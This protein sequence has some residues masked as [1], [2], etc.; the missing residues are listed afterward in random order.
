VNRA[1]EATRASHW[2][3][4]AIAIGASCL[5][6]AT[7]INKTWYPW[8]EGTLGQMAERTLAG[9]LPHRE[10][11]DTYTGGLTFYNAAIFWLFGTDLIWL[12][13]AMVPFFVGFVVAMYYIGTHLLAPAG[14]A[15]LTLAA[16]VW[17]LPTYPAAI[18][19]WYGLFL[20][21]IGI[22]AILR[23]LETGRSRWLVG[24]GLAG[25]VS[26]V[27]K[28]V[29]AYYVLGVLLFFAFRAVS[30]C[31]GGWRRPRAAAFAPG[32]I[33]LLVAGFTLSIVDPRLTSAELIAF[34]VPNVTVCLAVV[35]LAF[36]SGATMGDLAEIARR[37]VLPFVGG[38]LA[39]VMVFCVPYV[40]TG[41]LG[42]LIHDVIV[43]PRNRYQYAAQPPLS[44]GHLHSAIPFVLLF[45]ITWLPRRPRDIAAGIVAVG[46]L[47]LA[48]VPT[49][50]RADVYFT[51]PARELVP[52]L[53]IAA[54]GVLVRSRSARGD[55]LALLAFVM[56]LMT[57]VQFPFAVTGYFFYVF[58]L[59]L[60]AAVALVTTAD[61]QPRPMFA[62]VLVAYL[63]TG[64]LHVN[65]GL[66][67]TWRSLTGAHRNLVELDAVRGRI[68]VPRSD[69]ATF[70]AVDHLLAAHARGGYT[71]AGPDTPEIYFLT[72]LQNPTP[73]I[74]DFL[75]PP[76]DHD[77]LILEGIARHHVTAVVLNS[78]PQF[79]PR[80]DDDLQQRLDSMY[81]E[82]QTIGAY[83]VRWRA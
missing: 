65:V 14:A 22:A 19:S 34:L 79:S 77:R 51:T 40:V 59:V 67:D 72:N 32:A 24:A 70:Q 5:D 62:A 47:V 2:P 58:P 7:V 45:V 60:L 61:L 83:D 25:G 75:S 52:L 69:A 29:G 11:V 8:D 48:F 23:W 15:V 46:Y 54:A 30:R 64:A 31:S 81:P 21:V 56:A 71:V 28:I 6:L 33:A 16:A 41:T 10:F 55:L 17:T 1:S 57:L 76:Q 37:E 3:F 73:M 42:P 39:P 44:I 9:Q 18:P 49:R 13:I 38:V 50:A 43:A 53:A 78:E 66:N 35:A 4:L 26:V 74:F 80:Y 82:H 27:I 68:D 12:R 63:I 36:R 20:A